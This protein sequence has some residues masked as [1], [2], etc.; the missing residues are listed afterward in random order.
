MEEHVQ[1]TLTNEM[2]RQSSR[3][4]GKFGVGRQP[5]S[6]DIDIPVI[7]CGMIEGEPI[8]EGVKLLWTHFGIVYTCDIYDVDGICIAGPTGDRRFWQEE[9]AK[10]FDIVFD[11]FEKRPECDMD[12]PEFLVAADCHIQNQELL[13][14]MASAKELKRLHKGHNSGTTVMTMRETYRD[15]NLPTSKE[16]TPEGGGQN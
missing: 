13:A 11:N 9:E 16:E 5:M 10:E 2:S 8:A 14:A 6:V 12:S 15:P 3:R 7:I 4:G 1:K